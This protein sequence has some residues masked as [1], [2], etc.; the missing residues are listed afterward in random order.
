MD[1]AELQKHLLMV[2]E[3]NYR[4]DRLFETGGIAALT[5]PV[6]I[7][8]IAAEAIMGNLEGFNVEQFHVCPGY[9]GNHVWAM[10]NH[11]PAAGP[12]QI[13]E[14]CSSHP[15]RRGRSDRRMRPIL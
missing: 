15:E 11:I 3:I 10:K 8:E 14:R 6:R 2:S 9:G 12:R 4:V 1:D 13:V 7:V 5:V